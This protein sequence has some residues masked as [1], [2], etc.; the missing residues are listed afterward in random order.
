MEKEEAL[1]NLEA[2]GIFEEDIEEVKINPPERP[3]FPFLIFM[4]ALFKD[5]ADWVTLGIG[6]T[7]INIIAVPIMF[8]YLSGKV[9]FVK[10]RLYKKYVFTM[11]LEFIP[12]INFIP[13][14]TIFVV[15]GYLS[16]IEQVEK[17]LGFLENLPKKI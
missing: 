1:E 16:E 11:I 5:I 17:I 15:R 10:K 3:E 7:I 9:G 4:L 14:N 2:E 6:G 12:F 13:Q 8:F